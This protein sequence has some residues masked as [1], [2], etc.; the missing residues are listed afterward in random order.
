M[1]SVDIVRKL[2]DMVGPFDLWEALRTWLSCAAEQRAAVESDC[3]ITTRV[4]EP[5]NTSGACCSALLGCTLEREP[6]NDNAQENQRVRCGPDRRL[7]EKRAVVC[8][9][10]HRKSDQA[11]GQAGA[12]H[13]PGQRE[14]NRSSDWVRA[15][16]AIEQAVRE[17][18]QHWLKTARS[19][20]ELLSHLN[21]QILRGCLQPNGLSSAA[22]LNSTLR[23]KVKGPCP[24]D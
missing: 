21:G 3:F 14:P 17:Q 23:L 1:F 11:T 12:N 8:S 24:R 5:A 10:E 18:K 22:P 6:G 13:E 7:R 2:E 20:K 15:K 4:T 16:P 19:S 9:A